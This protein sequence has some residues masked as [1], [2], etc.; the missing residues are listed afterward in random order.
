MRLIFSSFLLLFISLPYNLLFAQTENGAVIFHMQSSHT[1]FPDSARLKG[2]TGNH[3]FYNTAG[4]YSDSS[5]LIVAPKNLTADKK[6][7]LIFWFHGWHN[8][9]DTAV[10]YYQLSRQFIASG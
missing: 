8:N 10:A 3:V 4:H 1:S 2:H 6:V 5:V 7:D 9:I